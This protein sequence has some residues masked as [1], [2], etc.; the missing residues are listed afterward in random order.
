MRHTNVA[1]VEV[2]S[3]Q[4][5]GND[6]RREQALLAPATIA[7]SIRRSTAR[8]PGPP[9]GTARERGRHS[10]GNRS[11]GCFRASHERSSRE[12]AAGGTAHLLMTAAG[13]SIGRTS[14][15]HRRRSL[16]ARG[17]T[18]R[19]S[20]V[21]RA[22]DAHPVRARHIDR[23]I[24]PRWWPPSFTRSDQAGRIAGGGEPPKGSAP[25]RAKADPAAP[26]DAPNRARSSKRE[27]WRRPGAV[28]TLR[29]P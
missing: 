8:R 12:L 23:C 1:Y 21:F 4:S 14:K 25:A 11:P 22:A 19:Q 20:S 15:L 27:G 28:S 7:R 13:S 3:A 6:P 2:T 26:P 9:P 5:S 10:I 18:R 24:W 29:R 16:F 17:P